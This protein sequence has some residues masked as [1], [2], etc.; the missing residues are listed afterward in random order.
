[1]KIKPLNRYVVVEN[2][3]P[4]ERTESGLYVAKNND[5][6]ETHTATVVSVSEEY[7]YNLKKGDKVI[8]K[9]FRNVKI[10]QYELIK[11]DDIYGII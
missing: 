6:P 5:M 9:H 10:G 3:D 7:K 2:T 1:M 4:L 11:G 8:Y